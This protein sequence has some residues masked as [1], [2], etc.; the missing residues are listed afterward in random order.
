MS[1]QHNKEIKFGAV[2]VQ[3]NRE[4]INYTT[5]ENEI[6]AFEWNVQ[7]NIVLHWTNMPEFND[8]KLDIDI[9]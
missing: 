7:I 1:Q 3:E 5:K 8:F 9:K 6:N 2:R 4:K